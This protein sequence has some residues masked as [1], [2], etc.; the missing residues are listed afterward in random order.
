MATRSVKD[1]TLSILFNSKKTPTVLNESYTDEI[2]KLILKYEKP[3]YLYL[4]PSIW[5]FFMPIFLTI[6]TITQSTD[7]LYLAILIVFLFVLW[8]GAVKVSVFNILH[9]L[10]PGPEWIIDK[11]GVTIKSSLYKWD[12]IK[13]TYFLRMINGAESLRIETNT[14]ILELS[15]SEI[16]HSEE[17]LGH[18]IEVFKRDYSSA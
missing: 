17:E 3:S 1:R 8:F 12:E 10:N 15:I 16:S 14:K 2:D 13:N 11:N 9:F 4:W 18:C 5:P 6:L 7:G